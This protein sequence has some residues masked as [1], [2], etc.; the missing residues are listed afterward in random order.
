[1]TKRFIKA[2][3]DRVDEDI[4]ERST[5]MDRLAKIKIDGPEDFASRLDRYLNGE[6]VPKGISESES[7]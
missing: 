1:M 3:S 6:K 7:N 4:Q 2:E 5:L